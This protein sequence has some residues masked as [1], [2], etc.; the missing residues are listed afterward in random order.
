MISRIGNEIQETDLHIE[1]LETK[2]SNEVASIDIAGDDDEDDDDDCDSVN[3]SALN[4]PHLKHNSN[5]LQYVLTC[6]D[7]RVERAVKD[8]QEEMKDSLVII[9][10]SN[11][12]ALADAHSENN[13]A[14][15]DAHSENHSLIG[16]NNFDK[17]EPT[18][19]TLL[20]KQARRRRR[21]EYKVARKEE[22]K[23][24]RKV[25]EELIRLE[26]ELNSGMGNYAMA[27]DTISDPV[28]IQNT[29]SILGVVI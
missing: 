8:V 3:F 6:L 18:S 21:K 4:D 9:F 24:R 10:E 11:H 7:C 19:V 1:D 12:V 27:F 20:S 5:S 23:K 28:S 26:G 25:V 15:A 29:Q 13:V 14:I 22:R 2:L 16:T 17:P